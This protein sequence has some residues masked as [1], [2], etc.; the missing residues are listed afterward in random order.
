[1]LSRSRAMAR[2]FFLFLVFLFIPSLHSTPAPS[3]SGIL[4]DSGGNGVGMATVKLVS[5]DRKRDYSATTSAGG[6]FAFTAVAAGTYT[7]TVSAAGK[8][9]P[10]A[11]PMIIKDGGARTSGLQLTRR[12][13]EFRVAVTENAA[14]PQA[15][16]GEHLSTGEVSSLPLNERDFSKLLLLTAGTMTDAHRAANFT[17]QFSLTTLHASAALFPISSSYT[18]YPL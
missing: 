13:Q 6:E 14:L 18:T 5:A 8:I 1:M 3:W 9:W 16:G 4:R 2:A 15:S 17:Q 11:D 10:A 12:G 7:I